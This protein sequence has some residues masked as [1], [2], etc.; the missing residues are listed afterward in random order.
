MAFIGTPGSAT[1]AQ[2]LSGI[3]GMLNV[4]PNNSA[5]EIEAQDVRDVVYTLYDQIVGLSN[6]FSQFD[7]TYTNSEPVPVALGGINRLSTFDSVSIQGMFDQLLYPYVPPVLSISITS[8][9]NG[10]LEFGDNVNTVTLRTIVEA[11]RYDINLTTLTRPAGNDP[12][13]LSLFTPTKYTTSDV[14][15]PGNIPLLNTTTTF[16]LNVDD[17]TQTTTKSTDLTWSLRRYWGTL[18]VGHPLVGASSSTFSHSDLTSLSSDLSSSYVQ[19]RTITRTTSDYVVFIWPNNSVNLSTTPPKVSVGGF[20]VNAFTKTR[21]N[22]AFT[23]QYGY[24]SNY[25]VWVLN[26]QANDSLIYIIST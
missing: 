5:N 3:E 26:T 2:T 1:Y 19:T 12:T 16:T 20:G 8:P 15:T 11:K 24:V 6:S 4:L 7:I 21:D 25:D 23:N 14:T 9:S 17:G 13:V 22:I 10:K 18:P